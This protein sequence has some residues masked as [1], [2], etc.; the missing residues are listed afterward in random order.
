[1]ATGGNGISPRSKRIQLNP[2][3][4]EDTEM[5]SSVTGKLICLRRTITVNIITQTAV[6]FGVNSPSLCPVFPGLDPPWPW[7][8]WMQPLKTNERINEWLHDFYSE[9]SSKV[10]GLAQN[11]EC[12]SI[13]PHKVLTLSLNHQLTNHPPSLENIA[14]YTVHESQSEGKTKHGAC[15]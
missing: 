2:K 5:S 12:L 3:T 7:P 15:Q 8:G 13:F 1:M 14:A 6:Q 10:F 11:L 4:R 9:E